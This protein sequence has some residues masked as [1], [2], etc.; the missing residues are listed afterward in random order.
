MVTPPRVP[1]NARLV[2]LV[3][4]RLA[5]TLALSFLARFLAVAADTPDSIPLF[6]G[7]TLAGWR[8]PT[9][10][11][12]S[13]AAVSLAPTDAT[14]FRVSE[15]AGILLNGTP[16]RTVNLITDGE[17]GDVELHLEFCVPKNSNSGVYLMGRY[18]IQLYDSFGVAQD[19][20]PGIECGGIY[21]RWTQARGEF[22][23]HSP[24]VNASK[25][26]GE[27]QSFDIRFQAPRFDA[28]GRKVANARFLT[29]RH[30]GQL[31]HENIE[32]TGPTR[33]AV[34]EAERDEKPV[35]PLMLQGDHGPVA[36][37]NL[38]LRPLSSR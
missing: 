20:Y 38:R 8:N 11:W 37:R 19:K 2:S 12:K 35:G 34:W 28:A 18:E 4:R 26:P 21:P 6:D 36:Y 30:N 32:L 16:G 31:I 13:V 10:D 1:M 14:K 3:H 29:V 15:G 27:W 23:G 22:E 33:A 24:R 5:P 7:R 17:Y 9:G 25:P